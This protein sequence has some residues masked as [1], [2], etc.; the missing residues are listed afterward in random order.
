MD[1]PIDALD[2]LQHRVGDD[3]CAEHISFKKMMVV[4]DGACDVRLGCKMHHDV[5]L[6]D[7]RIDERRVADIAVPELEATAI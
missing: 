3:L 2:V 1:E 5:R 4:V 6:R 7:E